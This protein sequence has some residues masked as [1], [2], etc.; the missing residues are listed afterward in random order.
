[1]SRSRYVKAAAVAVAGAAALTLAGC[2]TDADVVNENL[3]KSADQ[4]ELTRRIVFF[5]GI[6]DKY[7]LSIEGRCNITDDGDQL[8][9]ICKVGGG[10]KKH[11]LGLSD[12]VSYFV[13]QVDVANVSADHYRVIFKPEVIVPNI[14]RP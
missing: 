6:T 13:E 10:Y 2:A 3:S 9:T 1:M 14:D 11:F 4:F 12:N 7:L 8:E 5:N